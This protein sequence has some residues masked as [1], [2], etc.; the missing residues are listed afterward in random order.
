MD[1]AAIYRECFVW[2]DHGGFELQ[3]DALI[4]AAQRADAM[5]EAG[6][7]D[8][9]VVWCRIVQVVEELLSGER[10]CDKSQRKRQKPI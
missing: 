10:P 7:M 1:A 6:D 3:P 9:H 4:E 8:G 2:D 5:L